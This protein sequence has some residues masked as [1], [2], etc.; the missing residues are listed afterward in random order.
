MYPSSEIERNLDAHIF[1][2]KDLT[3]LR[4]HVTEPTE[5][6]KEYQP[7]LKT[8]MRT[9]F[10]N[11]I[12]ECFN[13]CLKRLISFDNVDYVSFYMGPWCADQVLKLLVQEEILKISRLL[14]LNNVAPIKSH[15][16]AEKRLLID[17]TRTMNDYDARAK[18]QFNEISDKCRALLSILVDYV[19]RNSYHRAIIFVERRVTALALQKLIL[20]CGLLGQ[21]KVETLVGNKNGMKRNYSYQ[22]RIIERFKTG[23]INLLISTNIAEEG[24]D[25]QPCN[26]AIRFDY[27]RS[28]LSYIQSKGRARQVGSTYIVMQEKGSYKHDE[29]I[30]FMRTMQLN[31]Q[32]WCQMEASERFVELDQ[33]G[34]EL[35]LIDLGNDEDE[36][37]NIQSGAIITLQSAIPLVYR[38]CA[39]LYTDPYTS[40]SP[41]FDISNDMNLIP[42]YKCKLTLPPSIGIGVI[43]S[44]FE[45]NKNL[46]KQKCCLKACVRLYEL[47]LLDQYFLPNFEPILDEFDDAGFLDHKD[48][49]SSDGTWRSKK[50]YPIKEPDFWSS[51][52]KEEDW[53]CMCYVTILDTRNFDSQPLALATLNKMDQLPDQWFYYNSATIKLKFLHLNCILSNIGDFFKFT[54]FAFEAIFNKSFSCPQWKF[55]LIPLLPIIFSED[56]LISIEDY[57]DW[58]A[59]A[60]FKDPKSFKVVEEDMIVCDWLEHDKRY[61]VQ[62]IDRNQ[63]PTSSIPHSSDRLSYCDYYSKIYDVK[64]R[65]LGQPILMVKRL[66]IRL[67]FL[68]SYNETTKALKGTNKLFLLSEFVSI[69]PIRGGL[70]RTLTLLPSLF[71]RLNSLLLIREAKLRL[72]LPE[73]HDNLLLEAL[74]ASSSNMFINYERLELFGDAYLK[75]ISSIYLYFKYPLKNEGQLH[76]QR[77]RII[78]NKNLYTCFKNLQLYEF[79]T[80]KPL[81]R[82]RFCPPGF[83]LPNVQYINS[84]IHHSLADKALADMIEAML[85]ASVLSG[86]V[87]LGLKTCINLGL[88]PDKDIRDWT[89]FTSTVVAIKPNSGYVGL[90]QLE[91]IIGYKF[92]NQI[93]LLEAIT[94]A[95]Y[96]FSTCGC[97]QRLEF[98]GD[99]ILDYLSVAYLYGK[100]PTLSPGELTE[101]KDACCSNNLLSA[102]CELKGVFP[103]IKHFSSPLIGAIDAFINEIKQLRDDGLAF[104]EYWFHLTAPKVMADV[105]E[106]IIGAVFVDSNCSMEQVEL[107]FQRWFVPLYDQ[108]I[109]P[110]Q[111]IVHPCIELTRTIDR[112]GCQDLKIM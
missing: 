62:S 29:M 21:L 72:H 14:S 34:Y 89:C 51:S 15:Y 88:F 59:I 25:I 70:F 69:Y 50:E 19:N 16:Y 78:C 92:R 52:A 96:L 12:D 101:L 64:V 74:A 99:S 4:K 46:A 41:Y 23:K 20:E 7:P 27:F 3:E 60:L 98:L 79:V 109:F 91:T 111:V 40:S 47:D 85:A 18:F 112:I 104:K 71:L 108:H 1:A 90:D 63:S 48:W 95:S 42:R 37:K 6:I 77:I 36:F 61:F 67:N 86:G 31:L 44:G 49:Y 94:H 80:S 26:L 2:L 57:I 13:S 17:L 73:L 103:F 68:Q 43:E 5:L 45:K 9:R 81:V 8:S 106:A 22:T 10:Y 107:L 28:L 84:D 110:N 75:M 76:C 24:L 11:D 65:D 55:L 83:Q 30:Q 56:V 82:A 33:L 32:S 54:K 93:F 35:D 38:V 53:N 39:K 58:D 105:M 97:Y 66:N 100:Y 87:E 102:L